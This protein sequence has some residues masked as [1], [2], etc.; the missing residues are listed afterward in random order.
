MKKIALGLLQVAGLTVFSL[1]V[2]SITSLLHIPLPGSIIGMILLF[3]L[4]ES[5]V[6]RLNWVEAGASWLLAELLLF[7]IPSAI[8]VM[9]YS[10]LLESDGLQVLA[11]VLVGTFAVMASSGLLTG[12]IYK[13]KERRSL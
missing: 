6:I 7:F 11:V 10:K 1:L 4:L 13:V 9:N 5:G 2:N 12:V 3:L 8:G